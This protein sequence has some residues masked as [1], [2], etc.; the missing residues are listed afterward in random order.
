MKTQRGFLHPP[1]ERILK[2]CLDRTGGLKFCLFL[3]SVFPFLL[4]VYDEGRL[5]SR[6]F[7]VYDVP[8]LLREVDAFKV[9]EPAVMVD[10]VCRSP[11]FFLTRL[12][13][14]IVFAELARLW[15]MMD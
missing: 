4:W 8:R 14:E 5:L 12:S 11:V 13:S 7:Y 2:G 9:I 15:D 1:E 10:N 6:M 3:P